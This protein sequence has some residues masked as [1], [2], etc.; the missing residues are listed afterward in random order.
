LASGSRGFFVLADDNLCP[1][2]LVKVSKKRGVP[3]VGVLSLAVVT[4]LLAQFGFAT[5]VMAEVV[6]IV[7]L[8]I[9]LPLS[10]VKLR[11]LYPI[12]D[13]RKNNL[14]VMPGGDIGVYF[15]AG[16]VLVISVI[17]FMI[18]GTDYFLIGI[19][20]CSTGP[21]FY[22]IVKWVYGGV[23]DDKKYPLNPKTKLARGDL[24]NLSIY[25]LCAGVFSIFGSFFLSWYE[26]DWGEEYYAEEA[27]SPFFTD[28]HWMLDMLRYI[29]IGLVVFGIVMYF[30]ARK[31]DRK[32]I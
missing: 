27:E 16:I 1:R 10:V 9:L 11:K 20:A 32:K 6:F 28:F 17:A 30:L 29:G 31:Y 4:A 8:Y 23:K 3:Y 15:F 12:E 21:I 24:W 26:G 22:A 7:A 14:Y 25:G 5:L 18:N 19:I 13:R 2:F